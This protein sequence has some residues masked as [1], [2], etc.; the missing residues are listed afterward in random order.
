MPKQLSEGEQQIKSALGEQLFT[1]YKAVGTSKPKPQPLADLRSF[2]A[3]NSSV[4]GELEIAQNLALN[5]LFSGLEDGE[6]SREVF[7]AEA[8][9]LRQKL[10]VALAAPLEKLLIEQVVLCWLRHQFMEILHSQIMNNGSLAQ[11]QATTQMLSASQRR[12]LRA[13]E[14][15]ARV[16]KL[17]PA[18]LQVNI[19]QQQTVIG[20]AG[21]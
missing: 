5:S 19:A 21:E 16:R 1:L 11:Q 12:Y 20:N 14:T 10:G 3:K 15:L 8:K 2:L 6:R 18:V 9:A 4:F 17:G 13:I 7:V